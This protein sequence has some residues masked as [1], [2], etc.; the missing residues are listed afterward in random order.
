MQH[1]LFCS[2]EISQGSALRFVQQS[3]LTLRSQFNRWEHS[4]AWH[5]KSLHPSVLR[6]AEWLWCYATIGFSP[7]WP[8]HQHHV[9]T[10]IKCDRCFII[11]DLAVLRERVATICEALFLT[12]RLPEEFIGTTIHVC[13]RSFRKKINPHMTA[14]PILAPSY[15]SGPLVEPRCGPNLSIHMR[16][17]V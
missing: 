8:R 12:H 11:P 3:M 14:A 9:M 16:F 2:S 15:K 1:C 10:L 13:K 7:W 5:K 4:S 6:A 17:M